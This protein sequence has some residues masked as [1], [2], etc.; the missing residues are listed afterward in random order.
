MDK[1]VFENQLL[2]YTACFNKRDNKK[3]GNIG[4]ANLG[5]HQPRDFSRLVRVKIGHSPLLGLIKKK[6]LT[7]CGR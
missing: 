1:S 6:R 7:K 3:Q 4:T 5:A 2:K